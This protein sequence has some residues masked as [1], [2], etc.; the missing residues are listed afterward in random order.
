TCIR[1]AGLPAA[2]D[3]FLRKLSRRKGDSSDGEPC[4][5]V[6]LCQAAAN[7]DPDANS[8]GELSGVPRGTGGFPRQPGAGFL[9]GS[10][11]GICGSALGWA[12]KWNNWMD[13]ADCCGSY[14]VWNLCRLGSICV[15]GAG[16]A[17]QNFSRRFSTYSRVTAR[18]Y[19]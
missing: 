17:S 11:G 6:V 15:L 16:G 7:I 3:S 18:P 5:S 19:Y 1:P 8:G 13:F 9:C 12:G 4:V 2:C 10:A 14:G